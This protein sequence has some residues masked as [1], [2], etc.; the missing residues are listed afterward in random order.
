MAFNAP[1][2]ESERALMTVDELKRHF[3][4]NEMV[5][6]RAVNVGNSRD[7]LEQSG[8]MWRYF[9]CAAFLL[10]LAELFV[11]MRVTNCQNERAGE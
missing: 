4:E 11:A 5:S 2:L 9:L 8:S 3:P 7:A 10:M 6:A 1:G